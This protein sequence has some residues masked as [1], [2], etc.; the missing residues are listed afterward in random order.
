MLL[1]VSYHKEHD[2]TT[3]IWFSG[4]DLNGFRHIKPF[5]IP[6]S[7]IEASYY[8]KHEYIWIRGQDLNVF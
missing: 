2:Y 7:V 5:V 6:V 3:C 8:K 1:N 4:V